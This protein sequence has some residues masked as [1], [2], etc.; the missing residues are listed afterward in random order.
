MRGCRRVRDAET[1]FPDPLLLGKRAREYDS[2]SKFGGNA[3]ERIRL[4]Q[5]ADY[6]KLL[7]LPSR[8]EQ[9]PETFLPA[10]WAEFSVL[11]QSWVLVAEISEFLSSSSLDAEVR[12]NFVCCSHQNHQSK[13]PSYFPPRKPHVPPPFR[14]PPTG[15]KMTTRKPGLPF[16]KPPTPAPTV[17]KPI[18]DSHKID[19]PSSCGIPKVVGGSVSTKGRHPWIVALTNNG[20]QFCGGSLIRWGR[21]IIKRSPI[22][23]N[24]QNHLLCDT[25]FTAKILFWLQQ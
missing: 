13:Q 4:L 21:I 24:S 9:L 19:T 12:Q 20:R 23:S 5:Y 3:P 8:S 16:P 1:M 11:P 14:P 10:G 22:S 7:L 25:Y 15:V 6:G 18:E 2:K 17:P